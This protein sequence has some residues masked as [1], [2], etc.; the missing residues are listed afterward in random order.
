MKTNLGKLPPKFIFIWR[1]HVKILENGNFQTAVKI[2]WQVVL[3]QYFVFRNKF[4]CRIW[5]WHQ[6]C[7]R[8]NGYHKPR[9]DAENRL[10]ELGNWRPWRETPVE[11]KVKL[12]WKSVK[13][14][15]KWAITDFNGPNG[16]R[17]IP[18]QSQAFRQDDH[19]HFVGFQ[20]H[21]HLNMTSHTQCFKTMKKWKCSISVVFCLICLK[22]CRLLELNKGISPDFKFCCYVN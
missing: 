14:E 5:I 1:S 11:K 6:F 21:F 19:R 15:K 17:D 12:K 2:V 9:S 18:F 3:T 20:P 7:F 16:S 22:L 8:F 4:Q 10:R 13:N